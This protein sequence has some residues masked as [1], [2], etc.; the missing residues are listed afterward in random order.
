MIT[1]NESNLRQASVMCYL[2]CV[3]SLRK[4]K[5][6]YDEPIK[7]ISYINCAMQS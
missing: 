6:H 3:G 7:L 1:K 2:T 5:L 4:S